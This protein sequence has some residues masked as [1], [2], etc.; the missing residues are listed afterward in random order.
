MQP[1]SE[2]QRIAPNQALDWKALS[3][4]LAALLN[5]IQATHEE[6]KVPMRAAGGSQLKEI[7][8]TRKVTQQDLDTMRL[9][10]KKQDPV[11]MDRLTGEALAQAHAV[12]PV[13]PS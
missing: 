4:R 6:R 1:R 8:S 11:T 3:A 9:W 7:A 10:L 13:D 12:I 5:D 2:T